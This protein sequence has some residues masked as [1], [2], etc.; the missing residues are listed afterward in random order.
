V[1]LTVKLSNLS[2]CP[3]GEPVLSDGVP[4]GTEYR[5]HPDTIRRGFTYRC[6]KCGRTQSN[7]SVLFVENRDGLSGGPLPLALFDLPGFAA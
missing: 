3:C 7:I 1:S 6:G 4:L 2:I 5:V